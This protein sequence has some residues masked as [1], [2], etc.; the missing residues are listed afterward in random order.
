[1][2]ILSDYYRPATLD[3][4]I[5]LLARRERRLRPLAGGTLLVGQLESGA[6]RELDGV[7]DLQ[8]LG[9]RYLRQE[10][11]SLL[12]GALATLTDLVEDEAASALAT[13]LLRRA[14]QGEGPVNLRNVATVGGV[15]AAAEPDSEVYAALLAL[16]ARVTVHEIAL[17][18]RRTQM[19]ALAQLGAAQL[20]QSLVTE[21]QIPLTS[22]QGGAARVARTPSDRPIVAAYAVVSEV[23]ERVALCGVAPRPVLAGGPLTPPDDF[24]GSADYR[25]ALAE[26]VMRRALAAAYKVSR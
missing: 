9:L 10:D 24:K 5:T 25:R 13:G 1:M 21:V 7:V 11:D 19:V 6:L 16:D 22:G 26:V 20:D 23:G 17:Q 4:A 3:E 2:A 8:G 14:A 15:I 12:V 18:G